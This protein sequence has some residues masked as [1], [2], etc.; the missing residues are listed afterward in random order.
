MANTLTGIFQTLVVPATAAGAQAPKF[1]NGMI[2]R[3]YTQ[4]R[5]M[6]GEVGNTLNVVI[7]KV[8]VGNVVNIG[9][10]PISVQDRDHT[11]VPI[12][13]D[14][15]QSDAAVIRSFD[16]IR[17]PYDLQVQYTDA[18]MEEVLRKVNGSIAALATTG[19][20]NSYT[21]ITG[22]TNLFT[23]L[24]IASAWENLV[25]AGAPMNERDVF[26]IAHPIPYGTMIGDATQNFIQQYIVGEAGALA[27]QN[28]ARLMPQFQAQIDY[29]QQM[30]VV[31]TK[32]SALF[33]HRYA[34]A[35]VPVLQPPAGSAIVMETT[36][37]PRPGLPVRVQL[38]YDPQQQGYVLHMNCVYALKVVRPE[39][40]SYMEAA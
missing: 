5:G 4:Y 28:T 16:Q 19:N 37:Y 24:N 1:R 14:Q 10:G 3:V 11:T 26:M 17:T 21:T 35:L 7:P 2:E 32:Y 34:I 29:D 27:A 39:F 6:H 31:A 36:V 8:N 22:G 13:I 40:G 33:F 18:M 12:T 38:W 25:L 15:N 23:R 30:P 20:F 9:N